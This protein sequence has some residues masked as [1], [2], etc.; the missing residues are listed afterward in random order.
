MEEL[1]A[2]KK[3]LVYYYG[4][5][6][7]LL[8][9][10]N[11]LV[12]PHLSERQVQTVDY[13]T[14]MNMTQNQEIQQVEIGS[15]RIFFSDKSGTIYETAVMEDAGLVDRLHQSG[16]TF[17]RQIQQQT[18]PFISILLFWILPTLVF[19]GMGQVMSRHLTKKAGG[20]NFMTFGLGKALRRST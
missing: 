11:F 6:I 19:M 3:P 10:F 17:T 9:L 1:K 5:I 2:P 18:S 7:I 12:M 8:L 14:F 13:G 16:A 20:G 4:I 15:S